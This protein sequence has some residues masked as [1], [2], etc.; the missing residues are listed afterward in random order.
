MNNVIRIHS[1]SSVLCILDSK[2]ECDQLITSSP[3]C[4]Q[5]HEFLSP[6]SLS[7]FES[8]KEGLASL[9]L[10]FRV[11]P[12]L[13]RGLDYYSHTVFEM[14]LKPTAPSHL[15]SALG[16]SQSTLLAGG[17]YD[18]LVEKVAGKKVLNYD[19]LIAGLG[20]AAGVQRLL[21]LLKQM[22]PSAFM[23]TRN[24]L[25]LKRRLLSDSGVI[26]VLL[27]RIPPSTTSG[28]Q[29]SA[30][31]GYALKVA[32]TL[33]THGC[34]PLLADV[35]LVQGE[36]NHLPS[37]SKQLMKMMKQYTKEDFL[38]MGL[39]QDD[40]ETVEWCRLLQPVP[41][42]AVFIGEEE[43]S[44]SFITLKNLKSREQRRVSLTEQDG[45]WINDL[46]QRESV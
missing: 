22:G 26:P 34:V 1:K 36:N 24:R 31:S 21:L 45:C 13:V 20:W 9:G 30:L 8:V 41:Q 29:W 6:A 32:R 2:H 10:S 38:S 18:G 17:R 14:G 11:D 37:A 42:W 39:K 7:R 23:V 44:Q 3:V 28:Q 40:H 4:P 46:K 12:V 33:R 27:I 43:M 19:N 16:P 15:G 25:Q 35:P 5:L